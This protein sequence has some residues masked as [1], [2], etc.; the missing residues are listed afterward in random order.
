M[1]PAKQVELM[2]VA[3]DSSTEIVMDVAPG[4]RL[5]PEELVRLPPLESWRLER[6]LTQRSRLHNRQRNFTL[7]NGHYLEMRESLR[8]RERRAIFNLAFMDPAPRRHR[9][10]AWR[11]FIATAAA[12]VLAV[13]MY[14]LAGVVAAG[15]LL[16]AAVLIGFQ[17]LRRSRDQLV[18]FTNVG[19]VPAFALDLGL[20]GG[21]ESREFAE[22]VG[23]RAEGAAV[24]LPAGRE[25]LAVE[26]A[27]HRRLQESGAIGKRA[28]DKAKQRIFASFRG[29]RK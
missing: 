25:R 17:A 29:A 19:R 20:V 4:S 6:T 16:A 10:V 15:A 28:Y 24:L 11:W 1:I 27:E 12:L 21:R 18:F 26:M 5:M 22:L 9:R 23:E 7:F 8:S 3:V 2:A 13:S 14:F